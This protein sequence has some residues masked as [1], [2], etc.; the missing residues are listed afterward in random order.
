MRKLWHVDVDF[1]AVVDLCRVATTF[2][3][4]P[5]ISVLYP[6]AYFNRISRESSSSQELGSVEQM[7][8]FSDADF[9]PLICLPGLRCDGVGV[10]I[11]R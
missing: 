5:I 7:D 2:M 3:T 9:K 4:S 11:E 10:F 6:P 1:G 8:D